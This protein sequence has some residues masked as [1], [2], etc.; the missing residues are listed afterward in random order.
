MSKTACTMHLDPEAL[1]TAGNKTTL[2][3]PAVASSPIDMRKAL[4]V[5][6]QLQDQARRK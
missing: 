4:P 6:Q 5:V 2:T 3:L 1:I